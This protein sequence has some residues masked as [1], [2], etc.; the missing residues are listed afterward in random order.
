MSFWSSCVNNITI[1]RIHDCQVR[2]SFSAYISLDV[3]IRAQGQGP[4]GT[5]GAEGLRALLQ[6]VGHTFMA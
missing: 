1:I 3:A 5:P 6:I 4:Y 2:H